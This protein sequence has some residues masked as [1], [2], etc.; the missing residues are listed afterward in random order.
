M[1]HLRRSS[2]L[3][4][5]SKLSG[6]LSR[7]WE[8]QRAGSVGNAGNSLRGQGSP[9]RRKGQCCQLAEKSAHYSPK[10]APEFVERS[11][12]KLSFISNIILLFIYISPNF[13]VLRPIKMLNFEKEATFFC[14]TGRKILLSIGNAGEG[15]H[16]VQSGQLPL[17]DVPRVRRQGGEIWPWTQ[18][19]ALDAAHYFMLSFCFHIIRKL[20]CDTLAA[21]MGDDG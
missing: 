4:R 7:G 10:Q 3:H 19:R 2:S 8:A 15:A 1:I 14:R 16:Q 18:A 17:D 11:A 5:V 21:R 20:V 6:I 12:V 13:F 9:A